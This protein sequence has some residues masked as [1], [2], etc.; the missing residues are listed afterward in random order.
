VHDINLR[1]LLKIDSASIERTATVDIDD[2]NLASYLG[3]WLAKALD[4]LCRSLCS[5]GVT[6]LQHETLIE[7]ISESEPDSTYGDDILDPIYKA[8]QK[9]SFR[10]YEQR[11]TDRIK[12]AAS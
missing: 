10:W 1:L 3:E 5:R 9:A 7:A 8:C 12:K 2:E 6:V 4:D 11:T